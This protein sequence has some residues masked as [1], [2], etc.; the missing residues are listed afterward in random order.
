M[1]GAHQNLNGSRDLSSPRWGMVCHSWASTIYD[2][3]IHQIWRL[4]LHPPRIYERR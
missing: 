1:V 4:Y 3:P 2:Q